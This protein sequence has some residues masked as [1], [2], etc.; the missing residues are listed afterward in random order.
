MKVLE[1][2]NEYMKDKTK[3]FINGM[4]SEKGGLIKDI[5]DD[6]LVFEVLNEEE[7]PEDNT[8]ETIII[9]LAKIE[10][11]GLVPKKIVDIT[12]I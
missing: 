4:P 8:K 1:V 11:I 7:K 9:P 2:L 6:Y 10:I 5:Q 12:K 3:C